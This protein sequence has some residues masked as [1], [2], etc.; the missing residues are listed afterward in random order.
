MSSPNIAKIKENESLL[1]L[2]HCYLKAHAPEYI[3]KTNH[4]TDN[5][6]FMKRR[7]EETSQTC[8]RTQMIEQ[9]KILESDYKSY[10]ISMADDF[11]DQFG[12]NSLFLT[13]GPHIL[14][15]QLFNKNN[16]NNNNFSFNFHTGRTHTMR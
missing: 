3:E 14:H 15:Y 11:M 1:R 7:I 4:F 13:A 12:G 6:K 5:W 9:V 8:T 10:L 16:N 2:F